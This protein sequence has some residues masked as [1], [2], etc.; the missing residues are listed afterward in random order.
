MW[1]RKNIFFNCIPGTVNGICFIAKSQFCDTNVTKARKWILAV[2]F[3]MYLDKSYNFVIEISFFMSA[4]SQFHHEIVTD[5]Y[6]E[7]SP[8]W[9]ICNVSCIKVIILWQKCHLS[10]SIQ[11]HNFIMKLW[12]L[13]KKIACQKYTQ[14]QISLSQNYNFVMEMWHSLFKNRDPTLNLNNI[15]FLSKSHSHVIYLLIF[16]PIIFLDQS[17]Y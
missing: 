4:M 9:I 12:K 15:A 2:E 8:T 5:A 17:K 14:L 16:I 3:V 11:C 10:L 6:K 7:I 13:L 1:R